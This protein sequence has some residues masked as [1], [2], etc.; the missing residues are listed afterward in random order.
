MSFRLH[1]SGQFACFPRPEIVDDRVSYDA[2]TPIAARR[3]FEAVYWRRE[4]R[5]EIEAIHVLKPIRFGC[6]TQDGVLPLDPGGDSTCTIQPGQ[7]QRA[8]RVVLLDP[9]YAIEAHFELTS[10]DGNP[11]QHA[12]MFARAVRQKRYFREP[13]LGLR[14][15]SAQ[16]T[17]LEEGKPPSASICEENMRCRDLGWMIHD[18]SRADGSLRFFR[19]NMVQGR[20]SVPPSGSAELFR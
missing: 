17:L 1:V 5:W 18:L 11:A 19:P 13:Y 8:R 3:I 9:A 15:Y 7:E 14:E 20:I 4:I 12:K 10:E 2:I 6:V 16:L